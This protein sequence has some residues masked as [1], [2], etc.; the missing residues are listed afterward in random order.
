MQINNKED[1]W[2]LV[3][4]K[5]ES[6]KELIHTFKHSEPKLKITAVRAEQFRQSV[7]EEIPDLDYEE[8]KRN[9]DQKLATV[10]SRTYWSIPE[11]T[12]CWNYSGFGVLCDLCSESWVLYEE[13]IDSNE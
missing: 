11:S 6:L 13:E 5:W 10:F 12:E 1:W 9:R 8:L 7:A 3:D 4:S 2:E